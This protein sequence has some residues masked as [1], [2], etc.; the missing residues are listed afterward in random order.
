M[1][2]KYL[3][4]LPFLVCHFLSADY[5]TEFIKYEAQPEFSRIVITY[6]TIRGHRGVDHFSN[7]SKKYEK[8]NMFH[9]SYYEGGPKHIKKVESMDGLE[10]KSVLTIYPPSGQGYGGAVA[11]NFIQVYFDGKLV[12]NSPFGYYHHSG[13]TIPKIVIHPQEQMLEVFCNKTEEGVVFG[14]IE[15]GDILLFTDGV[16]RRDKREYALPFSLD[17]TCLKGIDE[18]TIIDEGT[19]PI[20]ERKFK[21]LEKGEKRSFR[22]A[23]PFRVFCEDLL[24][25]RF[26]VNGVQVARVKEEGEGN[27]RFD[28]V[29]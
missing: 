11:W 17:L 16:I 22:V 29:E 6:E 20:V 21:K 27:Y 24:D 4:F 7:N 15:R 1:K 8:D 25:L 12:L 23:G 18:I 10:V 19:Y 13:S 14:F 26:E 9:T 28:L 5:Y 3:T 2:R